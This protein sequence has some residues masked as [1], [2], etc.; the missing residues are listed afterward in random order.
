MQWYYASEGEQR[1]P[2][3]ETDLREMVASGELQAENLVW[4]DGMGDWLP[5]G[6]VPELSTAITP[7]ETAGPAPVSEP[8]ATPGN[9]PYQPPVTPAGPSPAGADIPSYL[10]Q[11]IVVT[12]L[13]CQIFGIIAIVFAARVDGLKRAGD[14]AGAREASDKAKTWCLWGFISGLVVIVLYFFLLISGNVRQ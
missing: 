8:P 5:L 11:S 6:K 7:A 3:N 4:R 13:C 12:L 2:V 9:S 14:L 1:G 10:W